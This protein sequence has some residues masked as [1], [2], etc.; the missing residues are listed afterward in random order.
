MGLV[1]YSP[2]DH[3]ESDTTEQLTLSLSHFPDHISHHLR[4]GRVPGHCVCGGGGYPFLSSPDV[5][6]V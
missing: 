1:A 4:V 6:N 5:S 3:K 2:W